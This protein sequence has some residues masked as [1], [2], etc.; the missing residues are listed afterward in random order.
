MEPTV[1]MELTKQVTEEGIH[2]TADR[3]VDANGADGA[4]GVGKQLRHS[5]IT[6]TPSLFL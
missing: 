5:T 6:I 3:A 1:L 2:G 4:N